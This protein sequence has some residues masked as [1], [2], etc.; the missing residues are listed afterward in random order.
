MNQIL[1]L[2]YFLLPVYFADMAP[3]FFK[4]HLMSLAQPIDFG[5]KIFGKELLGENKTF[6]GLIVGVIV[7]SFI[8]YTQKIIAIN[9]IIIYANYSV[10][11]GF[12]LAFGTIFG[13]IFAS[14]I[15]RR[16]SIG[17]GQR[18]ILIDQIDGVLGAIF[19]SSF[20]L[21]YKT[22]DIF[23]MVLLTFFIKLFANFG[24]YLLHIRKNKW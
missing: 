21:T 23:L 3:V 16:L 11:L 15:K 18:F 8:F 7:G 12:F 2:L 10:L 19:V 9:S 1:S 5:I 22:N 6:R 13:D 17:P 24:G 14:F 4:N 20:I